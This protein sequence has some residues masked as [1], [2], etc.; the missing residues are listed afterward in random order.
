MDNLTPFTRVILLTLFF[1]ALDFVLTV[2]RRVIE[3]YASMEP[4]PHD[5]EAFLSLCFL[6]VIACYAMEIAKNTR[7]S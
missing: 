5:S 4:K 6:P 3:A 7:K 1:M 2:T